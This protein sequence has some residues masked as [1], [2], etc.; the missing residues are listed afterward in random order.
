MKY[1]AP[2]YEIEAVD[3]NDIVCSSAQVSTYTD[4]EG[5]TVEEHNYSFSSIFKPK[6][7]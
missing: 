4:K 2:L 3:T 1:T 6:S 7:F 5:N